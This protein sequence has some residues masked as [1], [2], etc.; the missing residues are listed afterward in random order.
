VQA[1]TTPGVEPAKKVLPAEIEPWCAEMMVRAIL[2][3]SR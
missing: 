1:G 3:R 2:S